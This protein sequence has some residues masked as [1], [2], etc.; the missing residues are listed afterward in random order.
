MS[1]GPTFEDILY[2]LQNNP[3]ASVRA[4]AAEILGQYVGDLSDA[5]YELAHRTLNN[6]LTDPDPS[7]IMSV[8]QSLGRYSRKARQQARDAKQAGERPAIAIK[9]CSVCGKPEAIADG[10][11][12]PQINCPYR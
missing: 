3:D 5:E 11:M 4:Q 1:E 7:V 12:C 9:V 8:M 6:A 10:A 2:H